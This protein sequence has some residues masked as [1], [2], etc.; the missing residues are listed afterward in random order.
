MEPGSSQW[1]PANGPDAMGTDFNGRNCLN[2]RQFFL[3]VKVV[4]HWNRLPR[5]AAETPSLEIFRTQAGNVL[6]YLL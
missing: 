1:Y 2:M 4:K 6:D 5:Q 3:C